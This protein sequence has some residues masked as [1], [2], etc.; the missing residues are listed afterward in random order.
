MAV[1]WT[2]MLR[3][4]VFFPWCRILDFPRRNFPL[5]GPSF[6]FRVAAFSSVRWISVKPRRDRGVRGRQIFFFFNAKKKLK[7]PVYFLII[8]LIIHYKRYT[9]VVLLNKDICTTYLMRPFGNTLRVAGIT[10]TLGFRVFT[11]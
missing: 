3:F 4:P 6:Y 1:S 7:K 9:T 11:A 2:F 10:C 5:F 8:I